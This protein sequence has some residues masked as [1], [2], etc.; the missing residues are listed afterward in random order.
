MKLHILYFTSRLHILGMHRW[1]RNACDCWG[2]R[3]CLSVTRDS[4]CCGWSSTTFLFVNRILEQVEDCGFW[5]LLLPCDVGLFHYWIIWSPSNYIAGCWGNAQYIV[6]DEDLKHFG[7]GLHYIRKLARTFEWLWRIW[8]VEVWSGRATHHNY[9]LLYKWRVPPSQSKH[10]DD[11][12]P[13]VLCI[14]KYFCPLVHLVIQLHQRNR[15]KSGLC[16]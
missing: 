7:V 8:W 11:P 16:S 4:F 13:L 9:H 14:V 3:W 12:K 5:F 10:S 6:G 2:L 15:I 1:V